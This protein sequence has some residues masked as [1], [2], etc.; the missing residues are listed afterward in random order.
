MLS[1]GVLFEL[2]QTDSDAT[3]ATG[4]Y[5][6]RPLLLAA[7]LTKL[8]SLATGVTGDL[9]P[10]VGQ[11]HVPVEHVLHHLKAVRGSCCVAEELRWEG[12]DPVVCAISTP[13]RHRVDVYQY[14]QPMSSKSIQQFL[15]TSV[16][17][18]R[19]RSVHENSSRQNESP[20]EMA[21]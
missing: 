12:I 5:K 20:L 2:H 9:L 7:R 4:N 13:T 16:S 19:R 17:P 3:D 18:T 6:G 1:V 8:L 10:R 11:P 14:L 15:S 21:G